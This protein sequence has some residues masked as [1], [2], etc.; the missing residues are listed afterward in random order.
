MGKRGRGR[1]RAFD[2]DEALERAAM[3]FGQRGFSAASL[4]DISEATGLVRPSI[5]NAFGDKLSLYRKVLAY[6]LSK[7][8]EILRRTMEGAAPLSLELP[9]FFE[10]MQSLF[11]REG[12]CVTLC[13]APA[14]AINHPELAE[15]MR[16]MFAAV[17]Q[18][19]HS[20]FE[21]AQ[22]RSELRSHITAEMAVHITQAALHSLALRIRA[23]A[24]EDELRNAGG[25][26][27]AVLTA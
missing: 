20:R 24:D 8:H 26:A 3:V 6:Q 11:V 15:D 14:E 23:G 7:N 27:V 16:I 5:Y 25:A 10:E 22:Q 1:P 17:G 2:T 13:T 9:R 18:L 19:L 12:G 21:L 4:D